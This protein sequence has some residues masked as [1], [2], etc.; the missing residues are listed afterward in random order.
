MP[1]LI[2][3]ER[4]NLATHPVIKEKWIQ[5]QIAEDPSILGLGD[6]VLKDKER[7]QP[8]AGRLD[9]LFQET[10]S[11]RRYEVEL[12][13]GKTDE[14][15]I[16]R[17]IEYWDIERKRYPQYDHCAVII[18]E[19]ITSRFLNIISLFNGH[20][21]L[22]ALQMSAFKFGEDIALVFTKVVDELQLGLVDEDEELQEPSDREYWIKRGSQETVK[23]ADEVLA[24][25]NEFTADVVFK[26]NKFYI[27]LA[28]NG[29]PFNFVIF[30]PRSKGALNVEFKLPYTDDIQTIIDNE[31][32][33]DMG[34]YKK[35]GNYRVRLTKQDIKNKREILKG[36]M[37]KAYE[38]YK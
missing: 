16:I 24:I 22:I 18:A 38:Y 9:L 21:P 3:P 8:R 28:K 31:G 10:E 13:L 5:E 19:D 32:L 7:S 15:H 12:Q 26:Y 36:L 33:D 27:G 2:K 1:K 30:R 17:T 37:Q 23:M 4:I 34:Y 29:Q 35:W 6:I 25:I 11:N 20:I 14:T